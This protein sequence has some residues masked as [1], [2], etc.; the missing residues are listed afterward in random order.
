MKRVKYGKKLKQEYNS[1]NI[2][3][4]QPAAL[5]FFLES[6]NISALIFR[7]GRLKL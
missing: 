1:K 2:I 4:F 3:I 5:L 7:T 6:S